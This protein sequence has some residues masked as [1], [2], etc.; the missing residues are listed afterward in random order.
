MLATYEGFEVISALEME[1]FDPE[2]FVRRR[3]QEALRRLK[4]EGVAPTM[5]TEEVLRLTRGR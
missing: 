5:S 2:K 3:T 4:E 1:D